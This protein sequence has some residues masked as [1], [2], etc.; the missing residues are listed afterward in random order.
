MGATRLAGIVVL[1]AGLLFAGCD[2]WGISDPLDP[3]ADPGGVVTDVTDPGMADDPGNG[4]DAA[5]PDD[6]PILEL[7][8]DDVQGDPGQEDIPV[9][10]LD[11]CNGISFQ[12]C[13]DQSLLKWCDEGKINEIDCG[14]MDKKCGWYDTSKSYVCADSDAAEPT[15]TFPRDCP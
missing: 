15:G 13:C 14:K 1:C 9:I 11:P 3:F 7:P 2:W 5:M 10:P 4:T 8:A 6:I 12:G